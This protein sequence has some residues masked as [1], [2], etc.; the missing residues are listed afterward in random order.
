MRNSK[1][2]LALA[3]AAAMT[4]GMATTAFAEADDKEDTTPPTSTT[5]PADEDK[6][7]D[8]NVKDEDKKDDADVKDED[9][10]DDADVKDEDKKD[11]ADVKDEDKKDD[12]DAKDEDKKDDA[13]A[14]DEDKKD[15]A[16]VKDEDKKDDAPAA[17]VTY[18][19]VGERWFAGAVAFVTEKKL[20]DG[21]T[22]TTFGPDEKMT[23]QM[24]AVALYRLAGSPAVT[25]ENPFTDVAADAAYKD[26]VV[27]AYSVGVVNGVTETTFNPDGNIQRQAIAAMLARYLGIDTTEAGDLSAF[28]DADAIQDYAKAAM[29]WAAKNELLKGD[30][31]GAVDPRGDA[32]R[33]QV[34]TILERFAPMAEGKAPTAA[35]ADDANTSADDANAP[36]G[37][38]TTPD[39]ADKKDDAA[40]D[41]DKKD[42]AD[43]DEDKK[44]DADKDEDKKDDAAASDTDKADDTDKPADGD[45]ADDA[46]KP[47]EG[48]KADDSADKE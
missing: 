41:E 4:L 23:R 12:A 13:D 47:A 14:K 32:T 8:A 38:T 22:E 37:D 18:T 21:M 33:A 39:D 5:A 15:D 48:D 29:S 6:K 1:K 40:Q 42:D 16:D 35:P 19:D 34:A 26:A 45:K 44:D 25:A 46:D 17:A 11:D 30:T 3:L 31:K 27:W 24:L 20:M 28:T 43:K 10:K 9:K 36:A 7:D 2:L